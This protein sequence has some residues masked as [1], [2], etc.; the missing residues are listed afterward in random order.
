MSKEHLAIA[1]IPMQDYGE[2][3]DDKKALCTGTIFEA[4]D[5]PFFATDSEKGN[6]KSALFGTEKKLPEQEERE[7][8]MTQITEVSF[9][10]DDLTLYLDTHGDEAQAL[11]L[12][13]QKLTE[14]ETL[15]KQFA[16]KFYPLTRE[17]IPYCG[18]KDD[19]RF[20]WQT[21]PMP[22]EGACV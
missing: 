14:R 12:F 4:L 10:I 2:I 8:L 5:M 19:G 11:S 9:V 6:K 7:Q 18:K 17:C 3:Y 15:K 13:E 21:G 16:E 22:W 1:N 20:C